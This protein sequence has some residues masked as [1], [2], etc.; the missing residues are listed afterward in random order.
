MSSLERMV[1]EMTTEQA[2]LRAERDTLADCMRSLQELQRQ[3]PPQPN[4]V[5]AQ[6][7]WVSKSHQSWDLAAVAASLKY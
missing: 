2:Q 5:Q 1:R 7:S 6:V 4:D 3:Q